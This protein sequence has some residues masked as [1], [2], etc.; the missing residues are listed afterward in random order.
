MDIQSIISSGGGVEAI[1]SQ[2]G[3]PADTA[4]SGLNAL[5][6]AVLGGFKKTAQGQPEGLEG[7]LDSISGL[8]GGGLFDNVVGTQPT[9]VDTGNQLLGGIFGSREGSIAVAQHASSASGVDS[10]ILKKMLPLVAMLVAGAMAKGV[11]GG[12]AA[13]EGGGGLGG[14]LGGLLGG[15]AAGGLLGGLLGGGGAQAAPAGGLG[16]LGG[17]ASM[18]DMNGDGNPLDDI[19]GMAGKFAGR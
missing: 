7:L 17:L 10:S 15:G 5:L 16:S 1:A 6:P 9:A 13:P 12:V 18:L 3:I 19:L 8:G 14:M 4:Q 2:L 11:G